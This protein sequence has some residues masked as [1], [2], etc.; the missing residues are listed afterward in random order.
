MPSLLRLSRGIDA[1]NRRIGSIACWLTLALVLVAALNAIARYVERDVGLE[2][3]S[4]AWVELQWYLF[5]LVFLLGAPL[6]LRADR[7]V[8]V[9]VLYGGHTPRARAW[10]DLFGGLLLLLPFALAMVWFSLDYVSESWRLRETSSD[11]GG[12]ARYPLKTVIPVAFGLLFLQ[13]LSET[14]KRAAILGGA[15]A[16]EVGLAEDRPRVEEGA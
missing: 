16:E 3:S 11:A 5:S 14:I 6:T 4:N 9:D 10:I 15:T 8:R 13:G 2:V 7:H 12:L 1:L